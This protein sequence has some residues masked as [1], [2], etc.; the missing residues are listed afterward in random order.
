[1]REPVSVCTAAPWRV[2]DAE[3]RFV[4]MCS[5]IDLYNARRIVACLN[6]CE[7]ISTEAL[8]TLKPDPLAELRQLDILPSTDPQP[9]GSTRA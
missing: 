5:T 1:M 9:G 2:L 8:E 7:G 4:C 3:G 6:A